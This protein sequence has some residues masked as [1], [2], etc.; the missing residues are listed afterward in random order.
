MWLPLI[1]LGFGVA[2]IIEPL[3]FGVAF[4]LCMAEGLGL[5]EPIME[6]ALATVPAAAASASASIR[7]EKRMV[8]DLSSFKKQWLYEVRS[9][10]LVG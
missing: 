7:D 3:G 10:R 6:S 5:G 1:E 9:P 8:A 4:M 2:F